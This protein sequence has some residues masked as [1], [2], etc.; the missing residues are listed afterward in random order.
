MLKIDWQGSRAVPAIQHQAEGS[1]GVSQVTVVALGIL[2][3]SDRVVGL[4]VCSVKKH[5]EHNQV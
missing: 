1:S 3:D 2:D 4:K 5:L